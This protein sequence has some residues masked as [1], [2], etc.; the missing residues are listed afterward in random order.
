MQHKPSHEDV[1]WRDF[2]KAQPP[3]V[4]AE[5]AF[6]MAEQGNLWRV[7]QLLDMGMDIETEGAVRPSAPNMSLL[8]IAVE[9]GHHAL[10]A[11]LL[12][13]GADANLPDEVVEFP[14]NKAVRRGDKAM[15]SLLL[16]HDADPQ[17]KNEFGYNAFALAKAKPEILAILEDSL[18]KSRS[19]RPPHQAKG[20]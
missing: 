15:V 17:A 5:T 19:P 14:L 20:L 6:L 12:D 18:P 9:K 3:A 8:H 1:L 2:M 13:R 11:A 7:A 4:Q 16:H 10:A